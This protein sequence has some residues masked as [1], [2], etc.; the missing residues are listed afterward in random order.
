MIAIKKLPIPA[1]QS[2]FSNS[3]YRMDFIRLLFVFLLPPAAVAMQFGIDRHF[4]ISVIL[5]LL[6][7]VPGVVYAIYVMA[8][9][10]PGLSRLG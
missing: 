9:R 3:Y 6:G 1:N 4:W 8:S 2:L 7:F 5:T 10:R